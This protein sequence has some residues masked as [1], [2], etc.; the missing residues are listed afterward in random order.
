[1]AIVIAHMLTLFNVIILVGVAFAIKYLP[2]WLAITISLV[3]AL[4][5][6]ILTAVQGALLEDDDI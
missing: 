3:A 1:M 4:I 5:I 2:P 6:M